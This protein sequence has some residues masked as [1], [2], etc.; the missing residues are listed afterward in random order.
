MYHD[1]ET[2][3]LLGFSKE[4]IGALPVKRPPPPR[5]AARAP[6]GGSS[7]LPSATIYGPAKKPKPSAVTKN[8]AQTIKAAKK[9]AGKAVNAAISALKAA[10]STPRK[11]TLKPGLK[12]TGIK[13]TALGAVVPT[14]PKPVTPKAKAA[15]DKQKNAVAKAAAA[16]K[17]AQDA[18]LRAKK[19]VVDL[20]KKAGE[21]RT[22]SLKIRKKVAGR[23]GIRGLVELGM[24]EIGEAEAL[25]E[26][27]YTTLGAAPDQNNPGYL[28]DGSPDP[29]Y[30]GDPSA[31][32]PAADPAAGMNFDNLF[33]GTDPLEQEP[34]PPLPPDAHIPDMNAVGGIPYDG[35]KGRPPGYI[36]SKS[37]FYQTIVNPK[38]AER[39]YGFVFGGDP[40]NS[41]WPGDNFDKWVWVHGKK[42][43]SGSIPDFP[44]QE[45][46]VSGWWDN[47]DRINPSYADTASVAKA[48]IAKGYGV[49]MG[50]PAFPEFTGMRVDDAGNMF[51]LPN[52]A[53]DWLTAPLKL[54]AEA[55][56][57]AEREAAAAAK[58]AEDAA[59][60]KVKADA[61][62]AQS[63]QDAANALAESQAASEQAIAQSQQETQAQQLDIDQAK[64]EQQAMAQEQQYA[65]QQAQMQMSQQQVQA[66]QK[67]QTDQMLLEEARREQEYL[68]QHPEIEFAPEQGGEEGSGEYAEDYGEPTDEGFAEDYGDEG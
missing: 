30:W 12:A 54:A 11:V 40:H 20:A 67:Q 19:A 57:K 64:F 18:G 17:K 31:A 46:G 58:A 56:A 2:P 52:E 44:G 39:R 53:P 49:L 7:S 4:E 66:Q 21:Q 25:L 6:S 59:M 32:D 38:Y 37:Y 61:A 15:L 43:D 24:I 47:A 14:T 55:T 8:H 36:G 63:Q 22:A 51:W 65:M 26:E 68:A 60:E 45:P 23:T 41:A 16:K 10:K 29:A 1:D 62:L 50:N 3:T 34:G 42:G 27:Y 5:S 33:M 28:D 13:M 9:T 35:S 48:S